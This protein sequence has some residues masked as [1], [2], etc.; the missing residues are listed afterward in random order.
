MGDSGM[1]VRVM[2]REGWLEARSRFPEKIT[3]SLISIYTCG[4]L[5]IFLNGMGT[6]KAPDCG[7]GQ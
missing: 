7:G 6:R 1:V 5:E 3:E 4:W 2:M